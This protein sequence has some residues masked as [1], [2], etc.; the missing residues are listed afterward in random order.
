MHLL[1]GLL[2][3]RAEH[4]GNPVSVSFQLHALWKSGVLSEPPNFN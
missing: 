3:G 1:T 4:S 2:P